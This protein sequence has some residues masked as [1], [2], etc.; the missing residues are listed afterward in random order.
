MQIN[1]YH[2]KLF[3][4]NICIIIAW[5]MDTQEQL[6]KASV[7]WRCVVGGR[8]PRLACNRLL[9]LNIQG[10]ILLIYIQQKHEQSSYNK[11][12]IPTIHKD[13]FN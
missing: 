2:A 11:Q 6:W 9:T 1:P 4:L 10:F 5:Q 8:V 7:T 13:T 3:F 12:I